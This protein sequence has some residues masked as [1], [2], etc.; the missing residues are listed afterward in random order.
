MDKILDINWSK[1]FE[2]HLNSIDPEFIT[3]QEEVKYLLDETTKMYEEGEE[4]GVSDELWDAVQIRYNKLFDDSYSFGSP[5]YADKK[6]FMKD[7][8][9][10]TLKLQ[11]EED[12]DNLLSKIH[13]DSKEVKIYATPKYDGQ[14]VMLRISGGNITQAMTRG[15]NGKGTDLTSAFADFPPPLNIEN[16]DVR[17]EAVFTDLGFE[18]YKQYT[19]FDYKDKRSAVPSLIRKLQFNSINKEASRFLTLVPF[20]YENEEDDHISLK[21]LKI[22]NQLGGD[23][24]NYNSVEKLSM[25]KDQ[26]FFTI[27]SMMLDYTKFRKQLDIQLDGVVFY[28]QYGRDEP[29]RFA[30]KFEMYRVLTTL[31]GIEWDFSAKTGIYTPMGLIDV[32]YAG[33]Q[34]NRVS[35]ANAGRLLNEKFIPGDEVYFEYR[36]DVMGYLSKTEPVNLGNDVTTDF[37]SEFPNMLHTCEFCGEHLTLVESYDTNKEQKYSFLMCSNDSCSGKG[38]GKLL[39]HVKKLELKGL[40]DA[41]IKK[42]YDKLNITEIRDL[43]MLEENILIDVCEFGDKQ[44]VNIINSIHSKQEINDYEILGSLNIPGIS[45]RK[46]RML[47]EVFELNDFITLINNSAIEDSDD[48]ALVTN[49]I[50]N[51]QGFEKK[52]A[53]RLVE[54]SI[55]NIVDLEY[56]VSF[57]YPDF[58]STKQSLEKSKENKMFGVTFVITGALEHYENRDVLTKLIVSNGGKVVGSVSKNTN[59]LINNDINSTSGK[60]K[61]ANDLNIPIISEN[62]FMEMFL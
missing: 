32:K 14:S 28:L 2:K 52:L 55:K 44:A 38:Y 21:Y 54:Y 29:V 13:T 31:L 18:Q 40:D 27:K 62:D 43:Y 30:F 57:K 15:K 60:N 25:T 41:T 56:L 39:N 42:I 17:C 10:I 5:L 48:D 8:G 45:R 46:A 59:Y 20:Y 12:L 50:N 16:S 36:S 37:I 7:I 35:L 61:K 4:T 33:K 51:V 1:Q 53:K 58:I 3:R 6:H 23:L 26:V 34:F 49:I 9:G 11:N 22:Y 47:L 24:F 19:G